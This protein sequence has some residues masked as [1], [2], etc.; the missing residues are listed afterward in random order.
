MGNKRNKIQA[1]NPYC[2]PTNS[3]DKQQLVR[4]ELNP[5]RLSG[6][7]LNYYAKFIIK[8]LL[9]KSF[10]LLLIKKYHHGNINDGPILSQGTC[11]D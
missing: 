2:N 9:I 1:A 10:Y 5:G 3:T 6:S 7:K 8:L 4:K 11:Q